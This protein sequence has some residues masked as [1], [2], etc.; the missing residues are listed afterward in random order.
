[1]KHQNITLTLIILALGCFGFLPTMQ[2][3]SPPPDGAYPNF[4]TAEGQSALQSL[5]SGAANTALGAFTLFSTT[6]ANF[7]TAVGAGALDLNTGDSNTAVGV[8][9][10]LLNTGTENTGLG[11][12]ALGLNTAGAF[13]SAVGTFALYNNDTGSSNTAVGDFALQAV[14]AGDF[15]TALGANAGSDPDILSNNLYLGDAGAGGDENFIAIGN[16]S[17]SG[18]PYDAMF[19]G[20]VAGVA[21]D[22]AVAVPVYID[23]DTGQLGVLG[24][25]NGKKPAV[26]TRR[27]TQ[28]QS[29]LNQFQK[30]QKRIAELESTVA[31]LAATVK[32][33]AAQI[34]KVSAQLELRKPAGRVVVNK[35]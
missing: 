20:G 29:T 10:L 26:R 25:A 9:S 13:N 31:R 14:T 34:E 12:D 35:Q 23:S 5:T 18:I 7:N 17:A 28:R 8:A 24:P 6:T 3:V 27:V 11:V 21:L 4:T 15:N 30:Q 33:Q 2:S 19:V 1:M 16:V 22:P 32:E